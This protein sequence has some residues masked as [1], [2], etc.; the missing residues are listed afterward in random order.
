MTRHL[1][2]DTKSYDR[3]TLAPAAAQAGVTLRFYDFRLE[4]DTV[5]SVHDA[6]GVCVFVHDDLPRAV[7][8]Q[9]A[10]KGVRIVALRCAGF[11]NVDLG[12]AAEFDLRVVRV[13]A[14]SPHA[15]AEHAV[16]LLLA[17]NRRLTR[18]H[19]RVH[20][21]NF[22]LDGLVGF[23]LHG[24]TAGLIG[25]G[26]IG[27]ITAEILSGFGMKI[28]V[29]DPYPARPWAEQRGFEYVSSE[30][31]MAH[32]DVI[33]LHTPLTAET[34]YLIRKE[35]LALMKHGVYLVNVSRGGLVNAKDL[36]KALKKGRIGGVALDVYEEEEGVFFED[37]SG[38]YL[39]D[40]TL[41]RLL[42]FPNV[43][44]T[45]HQA[46][47]TREALDEIAD[48]TIENLS[49]HDNGRSYLPGTQLVPE[50]QA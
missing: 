10:E 12:A 11:N 14:Y 48:V 47:L 7:L 50:A 18:A 3:A 27:R 33:S 20:D 8:Q 25:T 49:R 5:D 44:I 9:L 45:S 30:D 43:L 29:S 38:D 34:E 22:S 31:L 24:K 26:K 4:P 13:P 17:L 32:S 37:H 23:D 28:L 42:T 41:A 40:D 35:T 15:V 19:N 39:L 6:E 2:F 46:F 21:L 1:V 36:I 16:A